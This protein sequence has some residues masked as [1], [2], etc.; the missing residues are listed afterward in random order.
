MA[1]PGRGLRKAGL[2]DRPVKV[3]LIVNLTA[4]VE[5]IRR[6]EEEARG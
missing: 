3:T 4:Y 5:E 1:S 2:M 6:R